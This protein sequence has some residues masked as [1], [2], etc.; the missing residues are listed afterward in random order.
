MSNIDRKKLK[1]ILNCYNSAT[2]L[3][4]QHSKAILMASN[5]LHNI[6]EMSQASS[7]KYTYSI[8][9]KYIDSTLRSC[10]KF[11]T[12]N[13]LIGYPVVVTKDEVYMEECRFCSENQECVK[14]FINNHNSQLKGKIK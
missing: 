8:I 6:T 13:K 9:N 5:L 12:K 14:K 4:L 2:S 1:I 10:K 3:G 11:S 7:E